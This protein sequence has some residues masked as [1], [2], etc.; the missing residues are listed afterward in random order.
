MG[1]LETALYSKKDVNEEYS[2]LI[3]MRSN[4]A[5]RTIQY[6]NAKKFGIHASEILVFAESY[7][8]RQ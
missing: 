7:R 8:Q 2:S 1:L 3:N 5:T 6:N 4:I